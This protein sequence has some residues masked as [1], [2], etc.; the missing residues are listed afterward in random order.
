M[1]LQQGRRQRTG[2]RSRQDGRR[3][4]RHGLKI[5][6]F[7]AWD[8]A[9]TTYEALATKIKRSGADAVFIGG[10][11]CENGGKLVKDLNAGLGSAVVEGAGTAAE[12][13][14]VSVAGKAF[15]VGLGKVA[16][17]EPNPYSV[18]A[19]QAAEVLIAAIA[20]SDGSRGSISAQLFNTKVKNGLLGPFTIN[21]NGD[22]SSNPV[23]IYKIKGGKS[24]DF[25]II[26][27]PVSLVAAA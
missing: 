23:A 11:V 10:L 5:A 4:D 12:G 18:Y 27:P 20:R 13:L 7:E 25:K 9:S 2:V 1:G 17:N 16:G 14:L 24:T 22:T 8:P 3:R 15:I 26:V 21:K 19:A 6:G